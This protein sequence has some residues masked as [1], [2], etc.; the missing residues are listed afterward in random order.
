MT[1]KSAIPDRSDIDK[2]AHLPKIT[3][4]QKLF[5]MPWPHIAPGGTPKARFKHFQALATKWPQ[6]SPRRFIWNT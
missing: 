4:K 2:V 6:E 1:T 5:F 3:T